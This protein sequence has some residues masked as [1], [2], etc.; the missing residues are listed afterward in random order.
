MSRKEY[1]REDIDLY[2]V[3]CESPVHKSTKHCRICKV[4]VKD[5]DHHCRWVNNCIAA[6][7]R[8]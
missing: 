2:C 8:Q 1:V 5:F 3:D 6:S 4:C 7:N